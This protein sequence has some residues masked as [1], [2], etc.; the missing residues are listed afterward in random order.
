MTETAIDRT[1]QPTGWARTRRFLALLVPG[2]DEIRQHEPVFPPLVAGWVFSV[3]AAIASRPLILRAV[4]GEQP[5]AASTIQFV[6]VLAALI[7][8]LLMLL[9]AL[10]LTA[11]G[12]AALTLVG[13]E[14]RIRPLLS[15]LLYGEAILMFQGVAV[16]L[17]VHITTGGAVSS[18]QDLQLPLGLA[19]IVPPT[20]PVLWAV[21]QS[22]TLFHLAWFVFL[23]MAFRRCVGPGRARAFGLASLMWGAVLLFAAIRTQVSL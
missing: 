12:W 2:L 10:L 14:S 19:A 8:P 9:K 6:L 20:M 21:A 15:V 5:A 1:L 18:P 11:V 13:V 7:A 16:V 17:L 3:V 22:A 23:T 4:G